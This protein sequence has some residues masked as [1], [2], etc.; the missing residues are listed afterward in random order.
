MEW[1]STLV[2]FQQKYEKW[3]PLII[4]NQ[5][6]QREV[7][8]ELRWWRY[9]L[10]YSITKLYN[11]V[12]WD[13]RLPAALSQRRGHGR[14]NSCLEAAFILLLRINLPQSSW[15]LLV[16]IHYFPDAFRRSR[17][18]LKS[19]ENLQDLD[20]YELIGIDWWSSLVIYIREF[21]DVIHG[22]NDDAQELTKGQKWALGGSLL[23][24]QFF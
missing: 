11:D 13:S 19:K 21:G 23:S 22:G 3:C 9:D 15:V 20:L 5:S 12:R 17:S 6:E 16:F 24:F 7:C 2:S 14:G 8:L 4:R 10:C 1:D 18:A